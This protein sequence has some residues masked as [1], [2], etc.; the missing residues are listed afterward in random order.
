MIPAP[1]GPSLSYAAWLMK[2]SSDEATEILRPCIRELGRAWLPGPAEQS[3]G[4][5]SPPNPATGLLG[6]WLPW[7]ATWPAI[8]DDDETR[9]TPCHGV[10]SLRVAAWHFVIGLH[11]SGTANAAHERSPCAS[12][13]AAVFLAN[14]GAPGTWCGFLLGNRP[15]RNRP[16][17]RAVSI[18]NRR[19]YNLPV[20]N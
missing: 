12:S 7:C 3:R 16:R 6:T 5:L 9:P 8:D 10:V 2:P 1:P 13:S 11:R 14:H 17:G 19:E 15:C 4:S 18:K 20:C